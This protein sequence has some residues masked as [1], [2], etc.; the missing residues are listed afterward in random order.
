MKPRPLP[1]VFG[2]LTAMLIGLILAI[3]YV[4]VVPTEG[5]DGWTA[6]GLVASIFLFPAL[7]L[8]FTAIV[9]TPISVLWTLRKG[10]MSSGTAFL[11]GLGL[12]LVIAIIWGGPRGFTTRGATPLINVVVMILVGLTAL[13]CNWFVR[14]RL[15]TAERSSAEA[16]SAA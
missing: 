6:M 12:G 13:T 2:A 9:W 5:M 3:V 4:T 8:L 7:G 11:M 16:V 15:L 10:L 1:Y 14:R